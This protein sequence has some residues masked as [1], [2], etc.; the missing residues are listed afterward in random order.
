[1]GENST[2]GNYYD[3]I[4]I[5]G[6]PAGY[7]AA[8]YAARAEKKVLVIEKMLSGGQIASSD[9]LDN[10][11]G[12]ADGVGGMEFGQHL[13]KQ[14]RR[15]GAEISLEEVQDLRATEKKIFRVST[16]KGNYEGES[17]IIAS[18]V[19]PRKMGAPGEEEFI[20]RGVS[21]CATCDGAFFRDGA[22]MVVGGGDSALEEAIYLTRFAKKVMVVHR[23]DELRGIK[24]LQ[25]KAF[26]NEKITFF[27]SH[28]VKE[29]KGEKK[30]E[31]VILEDIVRGEEKAVK[32]NGI[33]FYIGHNPNNEFLKNIPDLSMDGIGFIKTNEK[34]ETGIPG[35]YAAGDLRTKFLRQ[36]VTAVS[37]GAIAA[38]AA[39]KYLEEKE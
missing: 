27:L 12:I 6:G 29:I 4:I 24:Y 16:N 11:P 8:Q 13:E 3:I 26:K 36:V 7:A 38:M 10:Y 21:Y 22:V 33:F 9:I 5:G 2:L 19:S 23:R 31:V 37:D 15:F 30:V 1:M 25:E 18:G 39:I 35:L 32:I 34:M 17:V 20:G 14:A 28:K